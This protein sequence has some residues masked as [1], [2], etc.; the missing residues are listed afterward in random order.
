VVLHADF[1]GQAFVDQLN[2]TASLS[3]VAAE[4]PIFIYRLR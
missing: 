2:R 3:F 1:F 4:G